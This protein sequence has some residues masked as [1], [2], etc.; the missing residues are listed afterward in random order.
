MGANVSTSVKD[1]S[2]SLDQTM[3]QHCD[4]RAVTQQEIDNLRITNIDCPEIHIGNI[5]KIRTNCS[6][7]A[8]SQTLAENA[9]K[10]TA[11][12]QAGLGLN[13]STDVDVQKN[14]IKTKL[15]SSCSSPAIIKQKLKNIKLDGVKCNLLD[16]MNRG[17][18]RTQCLM[19]TVADTV[20]KLDSATEVKQKGFDPTTIF[21]IIAS[22]IGGLILLA[23]IYLL[24][25]GGSDSQSYPPPM[26]MYPRG[27]PQQYPR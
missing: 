7:D 2:S 1:I 9:A 17:D 13:I 10:L 18:A 22:V 11:Q 23:I 3:S 26:Y 8:M 16:L 27:Y 25:S 24:S 4:A 6:I 19:S 15:E 5:S 21:I 14:H 12:Q 20:S